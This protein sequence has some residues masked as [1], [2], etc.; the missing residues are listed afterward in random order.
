MST[1]VKDENEENETSNKKFSLLLIQR[2]IKNLEDKLNKNLYD[3][4]KSVKV[5]QEYDTNGYIDELNGNIPNFL[6]LPND[7]KLKIWRF[8]LYIATFISIM[9]SPMQIGYGTICIVNSSFMAVS[10]NVQ[11]F[12]CVIFG[13]DL[14]IEFFAPNYNNKG[15]LDYNLKNHLKKTLNSSSF[16]VSIICVLPFT[17]FLDNYTE[18]NCGKSGIDSLFRKIIMLFTLA[19]FSK[20][21][22]LFS[23]I[24]NSRTNHINSIRLIE[25][26]L[27]FF[28]CTNLFGFI[29]IGSTK[30]IDPISD[31][32]NNPDIR[33]FNTFFKV[34]FYTIFVGLTSMLTNDFSVVHYIEK[35]L[36][37]FTNLLSIAILANIFGFVAIVIEKMNSMSI[38][39]NT[40]LRER[41]DLI[42]EYLLYEDI[43][44]DTREKIVNVIRFTYQRQRMKF[45]D[46]Q[47]YNEI[48]SFL[49]ASIK[50]QLL[51]V[52]YFSN[53]ELFNSEFISPEFMMNCLIAMKGCVFNYNENI[54]EEGENTTDF[55][56]V[57]SN[58]KADVYIAGVQINTLIQGDFFGETAMFTSSH[59]RTATVSS[60]CVGDFQ[61][62]D[63]Q[64]FRNLLMN[65]SNE[66]NYFLNIAAKHLS[67]YEKIISP[68]NFTTFI[69]KKTTVF[70]S[71][72]KKNLYTEA[73]NQ[74]GKFFYERK[75]HDDE[76]HE[77]EDNEMTEECYETT[78]S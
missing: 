74:N 11:I 10:T 30:L 33:G 48:N 59:K 55:Y 43:P 19:R 61:R 54:I 25:I 28:Y 49:L 7:K 32:L 67:L 15:E 76:K 26:L 75:L 4:E 39:N 64:V 50:I 70:T 16:V 57:C 56:L 66:R 20:L 65:H 29:I 63:G 8:I 18:E 1:D 9:Y 46:Y 37:V 38:Q 40:D 22:T 51:K 24:E 60:K 2:K 41:I 13:L 62:I 72:L 23:M 31:L 78:K 58:S 5:F 12:L 71:I 47:L 6:L 27:F 17:L 34:Y 3:S 69:S 35:I 42:N 52:S 77:N 44:A 14:I 73:P 21:S 36:F 45:Y 68:E 53:D